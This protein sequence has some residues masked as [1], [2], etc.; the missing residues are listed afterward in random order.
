MTR[1]A[2]LF[3]VAEAGAARYFLPLW[4]R[5]T[6]R[7]L[8]Y[9]WEVVLGDGAHGVLRS[10][11]DFD[12]LPIVAVLDRQSGD[13]GS[14]LGNTRPS[15]LMA[16][17]GDSYPLERS[18]VE[19]ARR[20]GGR[21]AQA[22]DTWYNYARRFSGV[23]EVDLPDTIL[24]IDEKAR[25]EAKA[26]GLPAKRLSI[27]GQPWWECAPRWTPGPAGHVMFLGAPVRRDYG[28]SLGFDE[29]DAWKMVEMAAVMRPSAFKKIWYAKHPEQVAASLRLSRSVELVADT[30][31][32]LPQAGTVLGIFSGPMVDA[33]LAGARVISIQ[34]HPVGPDMCPWSRQGLVD[35]ATTP[36]E[37]LAALR[38]RSSSAR[39]LESTLRGST[40]RLEAFIQEEIIR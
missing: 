38:S 19:F 36:A 33:F 2:V 31:E 32:V 9:D 14:R 12:A 35:R 17:A 18:A 8:A 24:V 20:H 11:P 13:I 28:M 6:G 30:M 34:P 21:T 22:I 5:W 40:D 16:S 27:V 25:E 10:E 4:R 1:P 39:S 23:A 7:T 3:V 29:W 37:L 26:E 15:L